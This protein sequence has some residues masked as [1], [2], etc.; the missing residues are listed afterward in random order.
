[1]ITGLCNA[2]HEV[3]IDLRGHGSLGIAVCH[4]TF[5]LVIDSFLVLY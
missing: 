5:L 1:M 3:N 4:C 2:G